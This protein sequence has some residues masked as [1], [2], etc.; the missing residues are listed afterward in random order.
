[1]LVRAEIDE[2]LVDRV[3]HLGR[4]GVAAVNLVDRDDHGEPARHR[5]LEDVARLGQGAF[6]CVD[7]QQDRVDHEQRPLHLAAEVGVA[8]RVDDVQPDA[9]V[10]HG[11]LFGE[12]RDPLLP[13]E[14]TR[15]HD[16]VHDRL[17]R[18]KRPGL[19]EHRVHERGLAVVH[20]GD[21]RHVPEIGPDRGRAG[22]GGIGHGPADCAIAGS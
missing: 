21:D 3:E 11:R 10:V 20:V 5:L 1:V 6:G 2:E 17:V 18:P 8:G 19:A 13:L 9:L 12:D 4:A 16:P 7:E 22:G 14:V 15:V